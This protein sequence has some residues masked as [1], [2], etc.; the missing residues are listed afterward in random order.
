MQHSTETA[1]LKI[2]SDIFD[3]MD[4]HHVTI[5]VL[6]DLSTAFDTLDHDIL[7][8][9]LNYSY[10]IGGI[11]LRWIHSFLNGHI[12]VVNCASQQSS[13]SFLTSGVPQGSVSGPFFFSLYTAN[14]EFIAQSF[15]VS[16]HCYGDALQLHVP[17]QVEETAA[18]ED[19]LLRC[20]EAIDN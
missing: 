18:A 19:R 14:V 12:Q 20:M 6:L 13:H 4:D 8:H 10:G 9:Q 2:A 7:I 5:L 11:A 3:A 17:H 16:A 1:T 15:G